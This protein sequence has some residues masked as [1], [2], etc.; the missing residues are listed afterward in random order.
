MKILIYAFGSLGDVHPYLAIAKELEKRGHYITFATTDIY[1]DLITKNRLSFYKIRPDFIN[2]LN[3]EDIAKKAM[4]LKRG[5]EFIVRNII[6]K[7]IK[8]SYEDLYNIALKS[9]VLITHSLSYA[10]HI[11][12]EK[13]GMPWISCA[14]SPNVYLSKEDP[15]IFPLSPVFQ[16]LPLMGKTVNSIFINLI[17]YAVNH[18]I[19]LFMNLGRP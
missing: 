6:Y 15:S 18:G 10:G 12:A 2:Y 9:D 17:R 14:L 1:E 5:G 8:D 4:D 7:N 11:V 19:S 13:I 3:D 16:Y